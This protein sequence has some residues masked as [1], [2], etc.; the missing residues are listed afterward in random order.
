MYTQISLKRIIDALP[1]YA[2]R[3]LE[4]NGPDKVMVNIEDIFKC[5]DE[6]EFNE[7]VKEHQDDICYL[8]NH[9]DTDVILASL[10]ATEKLDT[11]DDDDIVSYLEE[12][13]YTVED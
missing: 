4:E 11:I 5:L 2:K 6:Y 9:V 13:G 7:F 3:E 10:S 12:R 1:I 8:S